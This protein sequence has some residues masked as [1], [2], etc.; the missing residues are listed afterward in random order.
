MCLSIYLSGCAYAR[1]LCFSTSSPIHYISDEKCLAFGMEPSHGIFVC[2]QI[3]ILFVNGILVSLSLAA[4]FIIRIRICMRIG[5]NVKN[6]DRYVVTRKM[7][8]FQSKSK[9]KSK[10][11][12]QLQT[13]TQ[14]LIH[15]NEVSKLNMRSEPTF[16]I[17]SNNGVCVLFFIS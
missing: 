17:A 11:T 16:K 2:T 15:H 9:S 4:H 3:V 14:A 6:C 1:A 10:P 12:Y 13:L 5:H 8:L 7:F